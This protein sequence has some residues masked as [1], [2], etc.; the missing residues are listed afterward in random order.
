VDTGDETRRWKF[1][2]N[3]AIALRRGFSN[4]ILMAKLR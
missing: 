4:D 2:P 3:V 1:H